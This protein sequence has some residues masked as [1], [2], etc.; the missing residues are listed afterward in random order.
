MQ[1]F[2]K[3]IAVASMVAF[4][5]AFTAACSEQPTAPRSQEDVALA[6]AQAELAVVAATIPGANNTDASSA[7]PPLLVR[8]TRMATQRL[9]AAGADEAKA[10]VMAELQARQE[11]LRAAVAA[12][13]TAQIREARRT[14]DVTAARIVVAVM[15]PRI[16]PEVIQTVMRQVRVLNGRLDEAAKAGHDVTR[17]RRV[18]LHVA[19]RLKESRQ[20]LENGTPVVALLIATNAADVLQTA[21]H[22]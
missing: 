15:S 21:F 3:R 12:N 19:T 9:T 8:L 20:A 7:P 6:A 1:Q 16:V 10:R 5:A 22:R 14:L 17:P 18:L 2:T 13:D 4:A 11:A